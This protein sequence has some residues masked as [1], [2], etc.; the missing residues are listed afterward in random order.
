MNKI[1][2][3][4]LVLI[5]VN[6]VQSKQYLY[7]PS[8]D[9]PY[10]QYNPSAPAAL[11]D[12][13]PLIGQAQ[14]QSYSRLDQNNWGAAVDM[15]WTFKYIMNGHAVQDST[16]KSD[17]TH[18]GSLRQYDTDHKQWNVHYYTTKSTPEFLPA[19][20]GGLEGDDLVFWREQKAPNGMDGFYR[21]TF[22]EI[23]E[24]GYQWIGEWVNKDST[25]TYPTWKISC[26]KINS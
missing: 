17:G 12:F 19:W 16:L 24:N 20:Q 26:I 5:V 14:C 23:S 22:Y 3:V 2:L 1:L 8:T 13:E 6:N 11:K 15:L 4:M 9:H 25:I 18:G 10:G 21:L 7:A